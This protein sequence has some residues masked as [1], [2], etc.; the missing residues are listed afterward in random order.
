VNYLEKKKMGQAL[1]LTNKIMGWIYGP[2]ITASFPFLPSFAFIFPLAT[3][4]RQ[5]NISLVAFR[6]Y[7]RDSGTRGESSLRELY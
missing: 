5:M 2:Y 6:F 7:Q 3:S 1:N 4:R